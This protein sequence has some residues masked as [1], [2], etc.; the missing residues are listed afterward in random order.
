[1]E[2][3]VDKHHRLESIKSP[4][5]ILVGGSNVAFGI[6]SKELERKVG[7]PVINMGIHASLGLEFMLNEVK[8]DIGKGDIII[9]SPEYYLS[10]GEDDL[11]SRTINFYP[12]ATSFQAT[13]FYEQ[14]VKEL[15][16]CVRKIQKNISQRNNITDT[17][18]IYKRSA[19][20]ENGDFIAHLSTES[21]RKVDDTHPIQKGDYSMYIE[22]LNDFQ[23][24]ANK[25]GAK[26]YFSYPSY[27]QSAFIKYEDAI[28]FY[29]TQLN[30]K[31]RIKILNK[32]ETFAYPNDYFFDTVYHLNS[33]GRQKRTAFLIEAIQKN[34]KIKKP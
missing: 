26:V 10:K 9:L 8:P 32:P 24:Y 3:I 1:M 28:R 34:I 31:L 23:E 4:R 18:N 6:D 22:K 29:E 17:N 5:I 13:T 21:L 12:R 19:F 30:E 27:A 14:K 7:L 11:I 33:V 25:R 20:D 16:N 2:V 15:A